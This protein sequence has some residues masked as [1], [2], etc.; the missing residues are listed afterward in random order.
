M[1]KFLIRLIKH[2]LIFLVLSIPL[3]LFGAM[4][5][6]AVLP[7]QRSKGLI[8]LPYFLRWFDNADIYLG[9]NTETYEKITK[10]SFLQHYLWLAWR[11]P[12]NYFNYA[13]LGF[14][15]K[16][17]VVTEYL[18]KIM[19]N[20]TVIENSSIGDSTGDTSGIYYEEILVGT[21]TYYEYYAVFKWT[22]AHC[23]R[24]RM[25]YKLGQALS[26]GWTEEVLVVSPWHSYSGQ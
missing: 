26:E 3:Q 6:L 14:Y 20:N 22:S 12:T 13:I 4:I 24:F 7:M 16:S 19:N 10:G 15:L 9:R 25:G 2:L 21:N 17:P 11:N 1:I 18:C 8:N 5:L 23:M